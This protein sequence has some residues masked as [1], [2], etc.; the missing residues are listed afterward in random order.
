MSV[1][2]CVFELQ[3]LALQENLRQLFSMNSASAEFNAW[4]A[5][6]LKRMD[7]DVDGEGWREGLVIGKGWMVR[8]G[9]RD[10]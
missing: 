5:D 2:V 7:T 4:V 3:L 10:W 8:G 6:E 1:C 9:G